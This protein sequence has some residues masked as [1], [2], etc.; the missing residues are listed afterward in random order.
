MHSRLQGPESLDDPGFHCSPFSWV[1]LYLPIG[2]LTIVKSF[3]VCADFYRVLRDM[4]I[5][6]SYSGIIRTEGTLSP[7]LWRGCSEW[8]PLWLSCDF[9]VVKVVFKSQGL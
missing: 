3:S 9:P 7:G 8:A 5:S 4:W 1:T 6:E 2:D